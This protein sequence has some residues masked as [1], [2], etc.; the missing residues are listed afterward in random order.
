MQAIDYVIERQPESDS[1]ED[2][3][4]ESLSP[5]IIAEQPAT[6]RQLTVTDAVMQLDLSDSQFVIFRNASHGQLNVIYRRP[7]GNIGWIDAA[8]ALSKQD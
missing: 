6:I 3:A 4:E 8:G 7:D 1:D 5:P 2:S